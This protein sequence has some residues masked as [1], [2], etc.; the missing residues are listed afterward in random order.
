[1]RD[2]KKE[3][4]DDKEAAL[5]PKEIN[6]AQLEGMCYC[7]GKKGHCSPKCPD[8]KL[9]KDWVINKTKEAAFIKTAVARGG[10]LQSVVS[11]PLAISQEDTPL[12]G[13]MA[14]RILLHQVQDQMKDRAVLDTASTVSVFCNEK[15]LVNIRQAQNKLQV[16]TNAGVLKADMKSN[17]PWHNMEVWYDPKATTNVI[18][19]ADLQAQFPECYK[20]Q[21]ADDFQVKTD[22]DILKFTQVSKNLYTHKMEITKVT[23]ETNMLST[24][25]ENRKYF[26]DRQLSKP[27]KQETCHEHWDVL[28]TLI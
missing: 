9:K 12:F 20:D 21:E 24:V 17:L 28:L 15:M 4:D 25:K 23:Q 1:L 11:A 27:S 26:T 16:H 14:C 5:T 22:R 2:D 7:C 3:K 13:W 8:K 18:S 10:D 19:F 6:F